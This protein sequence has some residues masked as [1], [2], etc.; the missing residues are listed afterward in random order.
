[1]ELLLAAGLGAAVGG[2]L[3]IGELMKAGLAYLPAIWAMAGIATLLV[4]FVPK[5]TAFVW[6][7]FGYTFV[8]LFM[9]RMM[10]LPDWAAKLTPF[11]S[12]P[13]LPVQEFTVIPLA[14]LSL[15][16]VC[17]IILGIWRFKERDVG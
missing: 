3:P 1:M 10:D 12:I 4:G 16:A 8:A 13:Q 17:F 11:G 2:E 7:M 15:A 14:V 5:L 9:G 6:A